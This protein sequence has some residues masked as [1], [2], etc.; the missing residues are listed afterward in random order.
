MPPRRSLSADLCSLGI[1]VLAFAQPA[2]AGDPGDDFS[3]N[4]F[5]DLAPLLALFGEQVAKQYLSQ[6]LTWLESVIF[7]M[8]PLGIITAII[9][10][11]RVGGPRWL[12]AVIGRAR[13]SKGEAELELMSSTSADVCELWN[14]E[15]I[16]RTLGSP[17]I[18]E[19]LWLEKTDDFETGSEDDDTSAEEDLLNPLM[20]E[21]DKIG[22]SAFGGVFSL[23]GAKA[24]KLIRAA[25]KHNLTGQQVSPQN[26]FEN[27]VYEL[28]ADPLVAPII[29]PI[30][31]QP[32]E[33]SESTSIICPPNLSLNVAGHPSSTPELALIA[34]CATIL[35]C[36]V[37]VFEIAI[38]YLQ[39]FNENFTK[40]GT[41]VG[42]YACPLT[43]IGTV[44]VVIGMYICSMIVQE[45]SKEETW[46]FDTLNIPPGYKLKVAWLQRHQVVTDQNFGAFCLYAPSN[47]HQLMSSWFNDHGKSQNFS[48]IFG[49]AISTVG[50]VVQFTGLRGMH[51]S[52][53]LAQLGATLIVS[54][55]RI[56]I[57]RQLGNRPALEVVPDGKELDWM[58]RKA[59]RCSKWAIKPLSLAEPPEDGDSGTFSARCK[60]RDICPWPLEDPSIAATTEYLARSLEEITNYIY[61]SNITLKE[62]AQRMVTLGF[63]VHIIY[64]RLG[65]TDKQRATI[66]LELHRDVML[67]DRNSAW[68]GWKTD[69][70]ALEAALTLWALSVAEDEEQP[71]IGYN[72]RSKSLIL[73]GPSSDFNILDYDMFIGNSDKCLR[74]ENGMNSLGTSQFPVPE[75]RVFGYIGSDPKQDH[76]GLV[77]TS[78]I[79]DLC[80]RHIFT[81]YFY[82]MCR[83][84]QAFNG[85]T[86]ALRRPELLAND[87]ALR[88]NNTNL[89]SMVDILHSNGMPGTRE[90]FLV[91]MVPALQKNGNL[92]RIFDAFSE[93]IQEVKNCELN[94][95]QPEFSK[96]MLFHMAGHALNK[97]R[98][99]SHWLYAGDFLFGLLETCQ[100]VLGVDHAWTQTAKAFASRS[101]HSLEAQIFC[102]LEFQTDDTARMQSL[103]SVCQSLTSYCDR[104]LGWESTESQM[105]RRLH[106]RT[107]ALAGLLKPANNSPLT[108][109]EILL[110]SNTFILAA[111]CS[112]PKVVGFCL[113][114]FKSICCPI[115]GGTGASFSTAVL[116]ATINKDETILDL[117][118]SSLGH[119]QIKLLDMGS[120][121]DDFNALQIA[122]QSGA[123]EIVNLLLRAGLSPKGPRQ[124]QDFKFSPIYLA[125]QQNSTAIISLLLFYGARHDS[126]DIQG[127]NT[128]LHYAIQEGAE[129]VIDYA[130]FTEPTLIPVLFIQDFNGNNV[131][132]QAIIYGRDEM[133]IRVLKAMV[134]FSEVDVREKT[135]LDGRTALH[136]ACQYNRPKIA[137]LLLSNSFVPGKQ[138]ADHFTAFEL[139]AIFGSCEVG[140]VLM[141]RNPESTTSQVGTGQW[142]I[143]LAVKHTETDY[144]KFLIDNGAEINVQEHATC[145]SPIMIAASTDNLEL[146]NLL[147][148]HGASITTTD[149]AGQTVMHLAAMSDSARC[150]QSLCG[151]SG[152]PPPEAAGMLSDRNSDGRTPLDTALWHGNFAAARV[153][154]GLMILCDH[155]ALQEQRSDGGSILHMICGLLSVEKETTAPARI[156][157][158]LR[159]YV[160]HVGEPHHQAID[161]ILER[162]LQTWNS[163]NIDQ[164]V[165]LIQ[166]VLAAKLA[167]VTEPD[168]YGFSALFYAAIAG[169][170]NACKLLLA[171]IK[172]TAS[173]QLQKALHAALYSGDSEVI[174]QL[175]AAGVDV[176]Q[177]FLDTGRTP[178]AQLLYVVNDARGQTTTTN[179]LPIDSAEAYD[180]RLWESDVELTACLKLLIDA[181]AEVPA[182]PSSEEDE[183]SLLHIAVPCRSA[184]VI[185]LL[186]AAGADINLGGRSKRSLLHYALDEK[187]T[188]LDLIPVLC[189]NGLDIDCMDSDDCTA[190]TLEI[191]K[192]RLATVTALLDNGASIQ[193]TGR[194]PTDLIVAARWG[195]SD[196]FALLC[197]RYKALPTTDDEYLAFLNA[198]MGPE[199][200]SAVH[201]AAQYGRNEILSFLK[202]NGAEIEALDNEGRNALSYALGSPTTIFLLIGKAGFD[203]NEKLTT[204]GYTAAHFAV[205][206]LD[207]EAQ[208]SDALRA[209]W[210]F[211]ADF[212][213]ADND[214]MTPF[215]YIG[216]GGS[217]AAWLAD[218]NAREAVRQV[219]QSYR[220]TDGLFRVYNEPSP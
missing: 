106:N 147:L 157:Y 203:P 138:T 207:N 113:A 112:Y 10:A 81:C 144:V 47:R 24:A 84:I 182:T 171:Q 20:E 50:F 96:D 174:K 72:E 4:L 93:I 195:A 85:Q 16:V 91:I 190:L 6:S 78:Y 100:T 38:T 168:V 8:A 44:L 161:K 175:V 3:N 120:T 164:A 94:D 23:Q 179:A 26:L 31:S 187:Q 152:M 97:F 42:A 35:Q 150:L 204:K 99:N 73:L 162:P 193:A 199:G 90:D 163:Q 22:L 133:A 166:F 176:N 33:Q 189:R 139:A 53:T 82:E 140:G 71:D 104:V 14:G 37:L 55:F 66:T 156:K 63:P 75:H 111:A 74:M 155:E 213:I 29:R 172:D 2:H 125:T 86:T 19:V 58:A 87:S 131:L 64:T 46:T 68:T 124:T 60:L 61:S 160:S 69:R 116:F 103:S 154:I 110:I 142:P 80:A 54:L 137:R 105:L 70:Y 28:E 40:E 151:T 185:D 36:G 143:I 186:V 41:P 89:D 95:M 21:G 177:P 208:A 51:Y 149:V 191:G 43:V 129:E 198:T 30:H 134:D 25:T 107:A 117:I 206:T 15:T 169:Q 194:E 197:N 148:T 122:C 128:F 181:G 114:K 127:G 135:T 180:K 214:G 205:L 219:F 201:I 5:S 132:D 67:D 59:T 92:L 159:Q 210:P 158:P 77:S 183:S 18:A 196:I 57:R 121:P 212:N 34:I 173:P 52:A 209:L 192:Q 167:D 123:V 165:E 12:R 126:R 48:T 145:L 217:A 45:R 1:I 56:L 76:L 202:E 119:D 65:S 98:S 39:P 178:M 13:E 170:A 141:E 216:L 215:D 218:E 32:S 118:L 200:W 136:L 146:F 109:E 62:E 220:G 27:D 153:L 101:C 11:I 188:Y 184:E 108:P 211:G 9:S 102:E 7:A 130:L 17:Y 115:A 49:T 83:L 88:I 79:Q